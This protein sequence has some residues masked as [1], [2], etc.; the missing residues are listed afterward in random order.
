MEG[1][2][3]GG[4][5]L[6][7]CKEPLNVYQWRGGVDGGSLLQPMPDVRDL[8]SVSEWVFLSLSA[9]LPVAKA[10]KYC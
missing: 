5:R 10:A 1:G 2:V 4:S 7:N 6:L 3:D 8:F 9:T